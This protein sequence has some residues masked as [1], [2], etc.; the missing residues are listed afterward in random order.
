M[1][2]SVGDCPLYLV[3]DGLTGSCMPSWR[4]AELV[5]EVLRGESERAVDGLGKRE[6]QAVV[7]GSKSIPLV[8]KARSLAA[9]LVG[10]GQ[11]H[12]ASS[13]R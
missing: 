6:F 1:P 8:W 11:D 10:V 7:G 3:S 5:V 9:S 2:A 4:G 13:S 12:L